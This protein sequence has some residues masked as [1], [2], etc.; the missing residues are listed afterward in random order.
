MRLDISS[1]IIP[2]ASKRLSMDGKTF[3]PDRTTVN[4]PRTLEASGT[5]K[6]CPL[7]DYL[8]SDERGKHSQRKL[9]SFLS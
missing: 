9:G 6:L 2:G 3:K 1:S 4:I 7:Q 8:K 5:R